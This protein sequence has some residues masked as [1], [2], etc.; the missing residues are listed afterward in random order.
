M[1]FMLMMQFPLGDWK[2]KGMGAWPAQDVH[3]P[4]GS[5]MC[6]EGADPESLCHR[7]T[8]SWLG[9]N[10]SQQHLPINLDRNRQL[11]HEVDRINSGPF[12][13]PLEKRP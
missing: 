5:P 2:T 6:S 4:P 8:P 11:P 3:K 13:R 7:V 1:K 12:I 10:P 9:R